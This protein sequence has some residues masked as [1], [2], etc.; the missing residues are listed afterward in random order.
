MPEDPSPGHVPGGGPFDAA[1]VR[2]FVHES[3][4][5]RSLYFS[6][7]EV[8]S[9][10]QLRDPIA[11]DLAYTRTMMGFVLFQPRPRSIAMIGLGG[12]SLAKF[13]YRHLPRSRIQVAEINPHVLALRSTFHVPPD[14]ARFSVLQVDGACF[15]RDCNTRPEVLLVDGF[16]A[17]GQPRQLAS[18]RFYDD[19]ADTLAPGGLLV[20]NLHYGHVQHDQCLQ[21]M[22]RSFGGALLVVD[23]GELSNSIVFARKG[24]VFEP[25]PPG[26][27]QRGGA[28]CAA[29]ARPLQAAFARIE[30]TL[31]DSHACDSLPPLDA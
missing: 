31:A 2:P 7:D 20:V 23:D 13:C 16:G 1:H 19:C 17:Q 4:R 21:R 25:L 28:L 6:I 30:R 10:M 15:V 9:R 24:P 3:L 26:A 5:S 18:Q 27:A 12:G 8:Q 14:D 11:L 22:G 29:A